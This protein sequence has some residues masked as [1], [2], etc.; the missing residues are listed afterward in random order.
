LYRYSDGGLRSTETSTG[1]TT[2]AYCY[3]DNA[4]RHGLTATTTATSCT[5]VIAAH[6]YDATANTTGRPNGTDTQSLTWSPEGQLGT[7]TEKSGSGTVKSTTSHVYDADG[8]VI[9]NADCQAA[10]AVGGTA[11]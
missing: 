2:G 3:G 9:P 1:D 6:A 4:H 5:G 7:L 11:S 10:R 8:T